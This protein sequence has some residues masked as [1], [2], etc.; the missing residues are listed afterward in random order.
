M[1]LDIV[2][3]KGSVWV[4]FA[5]GVIKVFSIRGTQL[6]SEWSRHSGSAW[7]RVLSAVSYG[8]FWGESK[9][10]VANKSYLKQDHPNHKHM[11]I[12]AL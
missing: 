8:P 7:P 1:C 9:N 11:S 6:L 5:T 10:R 12:C 3:G 2:D 4:G